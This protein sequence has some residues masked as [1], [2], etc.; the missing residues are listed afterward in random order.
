MPAWAPWTIGAAAAVM[1]AT[2]FVIARPSSSR[3]PVRTLAVLP[4][5]VLTPSPEADQ[6]SLGLADALITRLSALQG[7]VVRPVSAVRK[8][9]NVSIDPRQAGAELQADTVLEGT[10]Q[11]ADGVVRAS[12]R[13]VR[14]SDGEAL[15]SAGTDSVTGSFFA[16]QDILAEQVAANLRIRLSTSESDALARRTETNPAVHSLYVRGRYEWGRR[17]REGFERAADLFREAV[18]ID[19]SY[20]R[21]WAGLADSQLMLALYDYVPPLEM[22]PT[23]KSTAERALSLDPHLGEAEA[24][25]ALVSQNLD[26]NWPEVERHYRQATAMTPGYATAHHW[27]AEFLSILGR[28]D[29]SQREF[30]AARPIIQSRPRFR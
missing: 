1:L 11:T 17:N 4:F 19:P 2:V 10:L 24:T 9:V 30:A 8:F 6:L 12:V 25:L 22:L 7:V 13:L 18:D 16:V 14:A 29:E 21:A 3:A 20:A 27:Y 26:W 28:F 5:Q 15:W 23:A